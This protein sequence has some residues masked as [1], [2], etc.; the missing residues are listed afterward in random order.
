[1]IATFMVFGLV[2]GALFAAAGALLEP[3]LLRWRCRVRWLWLAMMFGTVY[4][5]VTAAISA[6][7]G[8][9]RIT[10]GTPS[11]AFP[12]VSNSRSISKTAALSPTT[13]EPRVVW[14]GARLARLRANAATYDRP[15][16]LLWIASS[17]VLALW[18]AAVTLATTHSFDGTRRSH[19]LSGTDDVIITTDVGPAAIGALRR[20]ILLPRWVLELEPGL[21]ALVMQHEREH[22]LARDPL[23]L[24]TAMTL[25]VLLPWQLPLWWMARRLRSAI[26]YDCDARV[27]YTEP[28]VQRYASLLVLV[29]AH[30]HPSRTTVP[31]L[32]HMVF[33][34]TASARAALRL[35]I[36]VMTQPR[37]AT[38]PVSSLASVA[39]AASIALV[40]M[41]LPTPSL[42]MH[43]QS[44][45]PAASPQTGTLRT[46]T[47]SVIEFRYVVGAY[48]M[49]H[50]N[51]LKSFM[52]LLQKTDLISDPHAGFTTIRVTSKSGRPTTVAMFVERTATER[53]F[54]MDTS[55]VRTPFSLVR[56]RDTPLLHIRSVNGDTILI[57]SPAAV[58][59]VWASKSSGLHFVL[60]GVN[61]LGVVQR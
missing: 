34:S 59:P 12:A 42:H 26:E 1:M 58:A 7:T 49:I 52:Y 18:L 23:L 41:S 61:S 51:G 11:L 8:S 2:V 57:T 60:W 24:L 33:M 53:T 20:R 10:A 47:D 39:A 21:R 3:V 22:L 5:L 19:A 31:L 38:R 17:V 46:P 36:L 29:S 6:P 16:L 14:T 15:L 40:A 27:L 9:D 35:R 4:I 43:A 55:R 50:E 54:K 44:V 37:R 28:D 48:T 45:P 13:L 30:R 32:A 25:I 56:D